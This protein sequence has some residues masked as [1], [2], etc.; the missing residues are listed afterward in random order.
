MADQ[1]QRNSDHFTGSQFV[2]PELHHIYC[3]YILT[4][5]VHT[6]M[7]RST[8][9]IYDSPKGGSAQGFMICFFFYPAITVVLRK[10]VTLLHCISCF[11]IRRHS[12]ISA[13]LR[14]SQC[15]KTKFKEAI[16]HVTPSPSGSFSSLPF[17]PPSTYV[18]TNTTTTPQVF[19][20][21]NRLHSS[22]VFML[23]P[24]GAPL[25][26][27]DGRCKKVMM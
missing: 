6:Y 17:P 8:H 13:S 19:G 11:L 25:K 18:T 16:V 22:R 15:R 24:C 7:Q 14:F 12:E 26:Q 4:T 21:C 3:F 27:I 5:R 20:E 2:F 23:S 1:G 10:D 9:R